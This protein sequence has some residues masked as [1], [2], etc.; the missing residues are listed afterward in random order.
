MLIALAQKHLEKEPWLSD[1]LDFRPRHQILLMGQS[2]IIV[3]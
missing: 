3:Q 1:A 2:M